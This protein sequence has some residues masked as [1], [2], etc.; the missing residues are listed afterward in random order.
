MEVKGAVSPNIDAGSGIPVLHHAGLAPDRPAPKRASEFPQFL[1]RQP[2]TNAGGMPFAQMQR[3]IRDLTPMI[4]HIAQQQVPACL[5]SLHVQPGGYGRVLTNPLG[6]CGWTPIECLIP[7]T[8]YAVFNIYPIASDKDKL[9]KVQTVPGNVYMKGVVKESG[10]P[11]TQKYTGSST[12]KYDYITLDFATMT[13]SYTGDAAAD[14]GDGND[15][16]EY[17][18]L[19]EVD[20]DENGK[21]SDI[22][23]RQCGDIHSPGNA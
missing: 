5:R 14:P 20:L 4:E 22:R 12:T 21:I 6:D 7:A 23:Y 1:A 8:Y 11:D 15:L 3:L 18:S 9:A 13:A 16:L 17:W 19:R 2:D 10:H